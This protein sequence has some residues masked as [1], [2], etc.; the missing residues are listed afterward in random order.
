MSDISSLLAAGTLLSV[1]GLGLYLYQSN[2]DND[3]EKEGSDEKE[4]EPEQIHLEQNK[5]QIA[6]RARKTSAI[7]KRP[8]GTVRRR[9]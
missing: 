2:N 6:S 8:R 7:R 3:A 5:E 1:G 9:T 4:S